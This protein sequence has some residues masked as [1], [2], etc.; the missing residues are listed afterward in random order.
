VLQEIE[1][2]RYEKEIIMRRQ[3]TTQPAEARRQHID[4]E[5]TK[6]AELRQTV[7]VLRQQE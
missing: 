7:D 3:V 6:L 5:R 4:R 2:L 1:R